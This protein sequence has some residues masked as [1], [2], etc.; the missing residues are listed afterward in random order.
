MTIDKAIKEH[1]ESAKIGEA[2]EVGSPMYEIGKEQRQVAEWLEDYK[3]QSEIKHNLQQAVKVSMEQIGELMRESYELKRMLKLAIDELEPLGS[4]GGSSYR[5]CEGCPYN[6]NDG[7]CS[8]K[9]NHHDEAM[10]LIG[11]EYEETDE[12]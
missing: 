7:R 3:K 6:A 2:Y 8:S 10:K 11:D 4:C 12:R 5:P 9:W 1:I